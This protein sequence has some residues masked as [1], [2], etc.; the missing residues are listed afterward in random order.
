MDQRTAQLETLRS[1][2]KQL[3]VTPEQLLADSTPAAVV[4]PTFDEYVWQVAE[5][6]SPGTRRV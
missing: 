3:G 2:L 1:L 5:A 6:V 4:V